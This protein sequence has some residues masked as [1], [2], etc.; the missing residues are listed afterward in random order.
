M[1]FRKGEGGRRKGS[2]NKFTNDAKEAFQLVFDGIG[3][4]DKFAEWAKRHQ[5]EFYKLYAKLIP[6]TFD[7]TI[8]KTANL[9][10]EIKSSH[11]LSSNGERSALLPASEAGPSIQ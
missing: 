2:L 4:I 7:G 6:L 11:E 8:D 5:T 10:I 1:K 3:G 9:I